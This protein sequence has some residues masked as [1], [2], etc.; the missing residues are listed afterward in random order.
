V[1]YRSNPDA[2]GTHQM[3]VLENGVVTNLDGSTV[4]VLNIGQWWNLDPNDTIWIEVNVGS[5]T[6]S[7]LVVRSY[8]MGF[9]DYTTSQY[10]TEGGLTE[11]DGATPPN[12]TILRKVIAVFVAGDQGQPTLAQSLTT[13]NLGIFNVPLQGQ[14]AIYPYPT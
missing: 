5:L 11:N 3:K 12:Q 9:S 7:Q 1:L 14:A 2:P 4:P 6:C 13:T 8:G 10:W